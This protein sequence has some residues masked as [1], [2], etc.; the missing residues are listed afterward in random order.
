[1]KYI[2]LSLLITLS[3]PL[4]QAQGNSEEADSE[5]SLDLFDGDVEETRNG[6]PQLSVSLGYMALSADGQ[7]DVALPNGDRVRIID[8][9]RLGV[10]DEDGTYWATVN[11]RSRTSRWGAWFGAW[12]FSGAGFRTWE[13][14][15]EIGDD[16]IVPVGAAVATEIS[17]DWYILEATY[18][19]IRNE[20][21]DVGLGFGF[22]VVDIET[23]LAAGARIGNYERSEVLT[24]LDAL[25]P[26]PNILGYAYSQFADRWH[27]TVRYG[28][29]GLS[30]NEY[31]GQMT[32]LHALLRY[33]LSKR[34]SL[35]AGYQFVKLDVDVEKPRYTGIFDMDFNGPMA[36]V[37]FNF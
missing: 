6:W 14:A 2:L 22:H 12:N 32:N 33:D 35:E 31:D 37:R 30:Y 29:F 4:A 18:S 34:W 17:T 7:F 16:L 3:A 10:D 24:K 15:L 9:D 21:W 11:W 5:E 28:W 20:T 25:A 13:D 19:F 8:L 27:L 36:V 26:L 23:T 1:M